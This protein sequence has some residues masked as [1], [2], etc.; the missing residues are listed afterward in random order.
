MPHEI[1]VRPWQIVATDLFHI[2]GHKYLLIV[3]YYSKFPFVRKLKEFSSQEVIK[4]TKQIFGEQGIPERV[5]SDNGPHYS[6]SLFKQFAREWGFEH[7]TSSP[8]YPQSNGLAERCVQAM[9]SAFR[10]AASSS[11]DL[12]MVLL[13]LRSTPIDHV[14]P[15]PGELLLNRKLVGNLPVKCP[16]N[17]TQKDK[18][19]TRLYQR[20]SYQKSQHDQHTRDLTE[21]QERQHVRVYDPDSSKW[22]PSVVTQKCVEARSYMV[23]TSSGKSLRRNRKHLRKDKSAARLNP[24]ASASSAMISPESNRGSAVGIATDR[25][26]MEQTSPATTNGRPVP[27][28]P[29]KTPNT[30][31]GAKKRSRSGRIIR[32]PKKFTYDEDSP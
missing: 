19:E 3:D 14:I 21:I 18:T 28:T 17:S 9:K 8:R 27:D 26:P 13:C 24:E 31:H 23:Q 15:S 7:Y 30:H 6:S 5:I 1:P 10:K 16:N 29:H 22:S 32:A 11:R 2:E 4:L 25:A 20:V 12:N